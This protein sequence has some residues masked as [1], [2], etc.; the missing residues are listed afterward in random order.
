MFNLG[1]GKRSE[2]ITIRCKLLG[3]AV[4]IEESD[5]ISNLNDK[6]VIRK[7]RYIYV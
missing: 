4:F 5:V 1:L 6:N 2:Y 3:T 7:G